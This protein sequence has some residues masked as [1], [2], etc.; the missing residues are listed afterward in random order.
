MRMNVKTIMKA[1]RSRG[2]VI[3][4]ANMVD[5]RELH[6]GPPL[7][8]VGHRVDGKEV[9]SVIDIEKYTVSLEFVE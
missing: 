5:F 4:D 2:D 1:E 8:I 7:L 3:E 9:Q 6:S